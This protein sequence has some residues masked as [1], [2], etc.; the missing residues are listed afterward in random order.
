MP[1]A[2]KPVRPRVDGMAFTHPFSAGSCAFSIT[3][4][5]TNGEVQRSVIRFDIR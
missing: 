5:L 1:R 4:T 3:I 2:Q